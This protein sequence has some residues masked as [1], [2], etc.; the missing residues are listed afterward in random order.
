MLARE[1]TPGHKR[2]TAYVVAGVGGSEPQ[3]HEPALQTEIVSEWCTLY[4][5]TYGKP[6]SGVDPEFNTTGW[7]S[8]YTGKP[9]DSGAMRAWRDRTVERLLAFR[10]SRVWEIG[11]GTGLL[12]LPMA[13]RCAAYLGTDF[14]ERAISALRRQLVGG[15]SH[16]TLSRREA[17]D[18]G[19][20]EPHSFDAVILNSIVQYFPSIQYLR[21][22]LE[23]A[24]RSVAPSGIVFVGDVRSLRCSRPSIPRYND[25][26]PLRIRLPRS[27]RSGSIER[28][29][30][31][32]SSSSLPST[33]ALCARRFQVWSTQRYGSGVVM[34]PMK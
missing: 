10:P 22:V 32:R 31:R 6:E 16:V 7:N 17:S 33:G 29:S 15:L 12:L 8:S 25:I 4:D 9:I 5:G 1:D 20:V 28:C 23:G 3:E 30:P 27:A 2:L 11:C 24:V 18:F 21:S 14:S 34:A 19:D 13:P 26:E